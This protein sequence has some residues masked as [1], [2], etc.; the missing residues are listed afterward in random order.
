MINNF[1]SFM[2][3]FNQMM[4]NPQ[5]YMMQRFG[6]PKDIADDPD[7]IIEKMM[8]NGRISQYQYNEARNMAQQI[9]QNPMFRQLIK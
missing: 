7:K 6:I 2:N 1:N 3:S 4:Q 9:Q 8:S 5:Q